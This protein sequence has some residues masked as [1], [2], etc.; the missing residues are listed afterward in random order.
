MVLLAASVAKPKP[1]PEFPPL[2]PVPRGKTNGGFRALFIVGG[3]VLIAAGALLGLVPGAPGVLLG[4]PGLFLIGLGIPS[5]G[6][7]INGKEETFSPKWR[8][9]LRPKLW[10][11]ARRELKKKMDVA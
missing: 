2:I 6:R 5:V 11:K 3:V 4:V 1:E 8:R 9:R 7:W 10:W